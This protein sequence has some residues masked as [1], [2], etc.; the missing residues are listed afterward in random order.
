VIRKNPVTVKRV[1]TPKRRHLSKI[2]V[3]LSPPQAR[4]LKQL[5]YY[6]LTVPEALTKQIGKGKQVDA[7]KEV[8]TK[9]SHNFAYVELY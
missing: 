9:L 7:I 4:A 5:S 6:T 8:M 3:E 2:V 1:V